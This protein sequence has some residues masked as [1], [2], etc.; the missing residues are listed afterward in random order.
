MGTFLSISNLADIMGVSLATAKKWRDGGTYPPRT[1][2][3]GR[4]GFYMEDL[5]GLE[6]VRAML[7]T[8]WK[9]ELDTIPSRPFTSIELFAG[10]GGLALGMEKAGFKHVMLNEFDAN[11]CQTLRLNRPEWN[12]IEGDVASVDFTPWRDKVDFISGGFP[13]QAFS[14][15]GKKGGLNDT[16]GTLFFQL[17]RAV[18]EIRPK[19]FMGENVKGLLSHENGR[20][21]DIIKNTISELGYTLIEPRVLKAIMYQVPQK[22]ER[23]I[24]VAI[25][26]DYADKVQ[27]EWPAPY[28][29]VMNLRDAFCA[30]ILYDTDVPLSPGQTYPEGK[31]KVME[32]VPEGGDWR[33]LPVEI[34]K[35]YMGGSFYLGGGKTGMARRLSMDEPSLTLTCAPAQKQTERCHS[36]ETRPLT[37]REYARIQTFPDDWQFA[38]TLSAQYKQIGNAVPINL[39]WAVGRSI[40]R[41]MNQIERID[42]GEAIKKADTTKKHTH[43][44]HYYT[45]EGEV[46]Q[47]S[48]FEPNCLYL[49]KENDNILVATC[50]Q[51]NKKWITSSLMYNYPI[52]SNETAAHPEL[53]TVEQLVV[54]Y[55]KTV[56]GHYKVVSVN[57]VGRKQ[58]QDLGYPVESS[59]HKSDTSYLLYKLEESKENIPDLNID[60]FKIITGK[61]VKNK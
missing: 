41:M 59:K 37:V 24:L 14:Y 33:D 1:D 43:E 7:K 47:L 23:L 57:I 58:L 54:M 53:L 39:A 52:V 61:G 38:G 21:L 25:R 50:R 18:N 29:R 32:L 27:F 51:G 6:P 3:K 44:V 12:V 10:G 2:G 48:L 46:I 5:V 13:C 55:R 36:T 26:N 9:E 56:V 4:E 45:P 49:S 15:A 19:V 35:Q 17:A 11:A 60:K 30:G 42:N 20:T 22:R 34:Q 31:R 28:E 40:I 8:K 16:R